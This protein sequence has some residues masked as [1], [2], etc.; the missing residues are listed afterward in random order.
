MSE[1]SAE[2][3]I[4]I[5]G[6]EVDT[7]VGSKVWVGYYAEKDMVCFKFV[8]QD[9]EITRLG[10]SPE[11]A[12]AM[13]RLIPKSIPTVESVVHEIRDKLVDKVAEALHLTKAGGFWKMVERDSL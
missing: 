13:V 2:I 12:R 6:W 7:S 9:G 5:P 1:E 11:A 3:Q 8:S 4:S 10:V